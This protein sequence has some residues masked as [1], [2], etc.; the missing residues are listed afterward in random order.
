MGCFFQPDDSVC[1]DSDLCDGGEV[2]DPINGNADALTGCV[3]LPGSLVC[4][5]SDGIACTDESCVPGVGCVSTPNDLHCT[6]CGEFCDPSKGGCAKPTCKP[7]T[8]QGK[9]YA[10][11]DCLDNDNDCQIDAYDPHCLGPCSDNESGFKGE[12][13]GQNNA[14]CKMDCYFDQ[15]SGAGN[16]DCHWDHRC[17]PNQPQLADGC[18][19]DPNFKFPGN[20]SCSDYFNAQSAQCAQ[21]VGQANV[22][23]YC[24]PL[25]PNGCDCFGCCVFP[26]VSYPVYLGSA[27]STQAPGTCNMNT[28]TDPTKCH[29]CVQVPSCLNTCLACEICV[30]KPNPGPG[31]QCCPTGK[32]KCGLLGQQPCADGFYCVTGCCAP[33]PN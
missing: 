13:P 10:C 1:Q 16:D 30:G 3:Q 22:S 11:G 33:N 26:Q 17:D 31:E 21:N 14:A 25:V 12:I 20:K 5:N 6:V 18:T 27:S 24:G 15:D 2:C 23:G 29:K 4:P 19:Y 28:L 9:I 7:A 32:Q 8:C